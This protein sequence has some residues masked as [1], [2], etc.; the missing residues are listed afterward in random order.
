MQAVN[1]ESKGTEGPLAR[2]AQFQDSGMGMGTGHQN[3]AI[4]QGGLT[5]GAGVPVEGD[6]M[7][8]NQRG[9]TAKRGAEGAAVG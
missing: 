5:Q 9:H 4:P 8:D 2:H 6:P 3:N 1:F 7:Y